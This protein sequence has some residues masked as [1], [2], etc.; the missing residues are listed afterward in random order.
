MVDART[1]ARTAPDS[2]LVVPAQAAVVAPAAELVARAPV[3]R[4]VEVPEEPAARVPVVRVVLVP[5]ATAVGQVL[6]AQGL[7]AV[8][9]VGPAR[10]VVLVGSGPRA[11]TGVRLAVVMD[12]GPVDPVAVRGLV[13]LTGMGIGTS[14]ATT[15]G[16]DTPGRAGMTRVNGIPSVDRCP[17]AG[18]VTTAMIVVGELVV[19]TGPAGTG[20]MTA[21]EPGEE[22]PSGTSAVT[23]AA[24]TGGMTVPAAAIAADLGVMS[25]PAVA[26]AVATR[27]TTVQASATVVATGVMSVRAVVTVVATDVTSVRAAAIVVATGVTSDPTVVTVAAIGVTS[28]RAVVTVVAT[29]GMTVAGVMTVAAAIVAATGAMSDPAVVPVAAI[30]VMTGVGAMSGLLE[31]ACV[32][33][34]VGAGRRGASVGRSDG[35]SVAVGMSGAVDLGGMTE[36]RSGLGRAGMTRSFRKGSP[37]PSWIVR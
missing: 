12:R 25:G 11:V 7:A 9:P 29:R 28:V 35:M 32:V 37:G 10:V 34:L 33:R 22:V 3:D 31:M 24:A 17:G 8:G 18:S 23:D 15:T 6:I 36:A 2:A 16:G 27:A 19:T 1:R 4:V 14:R 26:I 30:G 13:G 5:A 20:V 21:R